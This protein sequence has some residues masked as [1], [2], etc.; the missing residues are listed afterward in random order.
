VAPGKSFEVRLRLKIQPRFHLYANPTGSENLRP[1][2]V[3]LAANPDLTLD[4]I[5][6]PKGEGKVLESLGPERVNLYEKE[7]EILVRLKAKPN[8]KPGKGLATLKV[9]YQACDDRMCLAP[10]TRSVEI[11]VELR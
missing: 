11:P 10:A 4:S 8:A 6:Y 2:T 9:R 5:S 3:E 1:T 7:V